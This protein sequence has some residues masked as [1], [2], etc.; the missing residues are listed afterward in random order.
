MG[1]P[2]TPAT[3]EQRRRG[4]GR[5]PAA[6]VRAEILE[7][8][9][10]LLLEEG[11]RAFTFERVASE[12]GASRTTIH[13]WWPSK[14]ALALEAFSDTLDAR[15]EFPDTGDVAADLRVQLVGFVRAV[16]GTPTGR[17]LAEI[18]GQAQTDPELAALLDA[19]YTGRRR[20]IA[21][22]AIEAAQARGQIREGVDAE[23][24]ANQLWGAC[25]HRLLLAP[26]L[27]LDEALVDHLL[28]HLLHGVLA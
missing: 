8:A 27:P 24:M 14:G 3:S 13:K 22:R 2:S 7:A 23:V 9:G 19:D 4:R 12:S 17:A 15:L 26:S 21:V 11:M 18:I 10:A 25:F 28:D 6:E 1:T 5:R 20:A 16:G